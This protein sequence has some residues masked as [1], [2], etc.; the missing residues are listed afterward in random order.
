MIINTNAVI[1][2]D[3][4]T[5]AFTHIASRLTLRGEVPFLRDNELLM[6][7]SQL[8]NS[9]L[10]FQDYQSIF[11]INQLR[12]FALPDSVLPNCLKPV[13]HRDFGLLG[14]LI[15]RVVLLG[16]GVIA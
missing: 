7:F 4:H 10:I 11:S 15:S 14:V 12:F 9:D 1:E 3:C 13:L 5:G 16:F 8:N 6:N 2:H